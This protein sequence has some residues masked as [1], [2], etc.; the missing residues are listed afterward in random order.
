LKKNR[1]IGVDGASGGADKGKKEEGGE[2]AF[3][4][5]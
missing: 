2:K 1:N 5:W 4:V 3:F